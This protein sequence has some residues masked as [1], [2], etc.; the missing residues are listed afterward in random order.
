MNTFYKIVFKV[1]IVFTFLFLVI[2]LKNV[3]RIAA[4]ENLELIG[5]ENIS[6]SEA[7]D[8]VAQLYR[9]PFNDTF[10]LNIFGY[11]KIKDYNG[12]Y[13]PFWTN[14]KEKIIEIN[15]S[16]GIE[17]ISKH[18]FSG[19]KSVHDIKLPKTIKIIDDLAFSSSGITC[20]TIHANVEYIGNQAFYEC[21]ELVDVKFEENGKLTNI[22]RYAFS[23]CYSL[24]SIVLPNTVLQIGYGAFGS[25]M[26]LEEVVLPNS[27]NVISGGLFEDTN[28]K[29]I[30]IPDSVTEIE[31]FAFY[32]C[33]NLSSITFPKNLKT[34]GEQ[35]FGYCTSLSIVNFPE[36]VTSIERQAFI[37]CTSLTDVKMPKELEYLRL[38]A[39][40]ECT[41]LSNVFL[42]NKLD[43]I[44]S[45]VFLNCENLNCVY[46]DGTIESW[47]NIVFDSI[48]SN[49]MHYADNFFISNDA[50]EYDKLEEINLPNT[51]SEIGNYQFCGFKNV[52]N[53][54]FPSSIQ[55]ISDFAF[56]ECESLKIITIPNSVVSL[57]KNSFSDC[58]NLESISFEDETKVEIL[59]ENIFSNC[60]NLKKVDLA[61]GLKKIEDNAFS[62]V[63]YVEEINL[64]NSLVEIKSVPKCIQYNVYDNANY[65]GNKTNPYLYCVSAVNTDI[66]HCYI[67]EETKFIGEYAFRCCNNLLDLTIPNGIQRI[68]YYAFA[69]CDNIKYNLYK[70]VRYLGNEENPY[71]VVVGSEYDLKHYELAE[72]T[73]IIMKNEY[74]IFKNIIS[75]II[76]KNVIYIEEM[77]FANCSKLV[78]VYNLSNLDIIKGEYTHGFIASNA[79]V[80]HNCIDEPSIFETDS[81][82]G[83][84]F[85]NYQSECYLYSYIGNENDVVLPE[86]HNGVKY[87]IWKY[88]FSNSE[89]TSIVIPNTILKIDEWA[90]LNCNQLKKFVVPLGVE[91]EANIIASESVIYCQ[92]PSISCLHTMPNLLTLILHKNQVISKSFVNNYKKLSQFYMPEV[93]LINFDPTYFEE[94]IC[95]KLTL[96]GMEYPAHTSIKNKNT[97]IDYYFDRYIV[98]N[99]D[100][101]ETEIVEENQFYFITKNE[102]L[103]DNRKIYYL[104]AYLGTEKEIIIPSK[105]GD[106]NNPAIIIDS[107]SL[108]LSQMNYIKIS[109]KVIGICEEAIGSDSLSKVDITENLDF[110]HSNAIFKY[111]K[112]GSQVTTKYGGVTYVGKYAI[113]VDKTKTKIEFLEGTIGIAS[114]D[115]VGYE[116]SSKIEKVIFP[117]SLKFIGSNTWEIWGICSSLKEVVFSENSQL[118]SIGAFAFRGCYALKQIDLPNSI[119]EIGYG[120][121]NDCD[122]LTSFCIPEKVKI[123][124]E[125]ELQ[126]KIYINNELSL[127]KNSAYGV[128]RNCDKLENIDLSSTCLEKIPSLALAECPNLTT[129]KLNKNIKYIG[130][131]AFSDSDNINEVYYTGK[132]EDWCKIEFANAESNPIKQTNCFYVL[133]ETNEYIE[134]IEIEISDNIDQI[135]QYQFYGYE[136]LMKVKLPEMI[137]KIDDY[138]FFG[139]TGLKEFVIPF[140]VTDICENTFLDCYYLTDI[141]VDQYKNDIQFHPNWNYKANVYYKD[142]WY[143]V[144]L[145]DNNVEISSEIYLLNSPIN[146]DNFEINSSEGYCEFLYWEING[147]SKVLER[148]LIADQHYEIKAVYSHSYTTNITAPT[149]TKQGYTS[150]VCRCGDSYTDDYVDA[151]GHTEATDKAVEPTCTQTGLTEGKHCSVCN[152]VLVKQEVIEAL[153][154]DYEVVITAPTCTKQGYTTYTCHCGDSYYCFIFMT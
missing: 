136:K 27:L 130:A 31:I 73:K 93:E 100:F 65:L 9:N 72:T 16:E 59:P 128:W 17:N 95:D 142:E 52:T 119:E 33:R 5:E 154:H 99:E 129:I 102:Y 32:W 141:Y 50:S 134:V 125:I 139:C 147:N 131:A 153:G 7:D 70:N 107:Y 40:S 11:G 56:S 120:A 114:C 60:S 8:V 20:I 21:T 112:W 152:K 105:I 110:I 111:K 85:M 94:V 35:S 87:S 13:L 124:G 79:L 82:N 28:L 126:Q 104:K 149:C 122:S 106:D 15:I 2:N 117:A 58:N 54:F 45:Q 144:R 53:V 42:Y 80:V 137:R 63:N 92:V 26:E 96:L 23:A 55:K 47:C 81:D 6:S 4:N 25:C 97:G 115:E 143:I 46:Y 150:Y 75:I 61:E 51:I 135:G 76:P 14:Y 62:E 146:Y 18:C 84:L 34:I 123:I 37:G 103:D 86:Y 49:P 145:L 36:H 19:C 12:E 88:A 118:T 29:T 66:D 1:L 44:E 71:L 127:Y 41:S 57:G 24:K 69:D 109:D 89:I 116:N 91:C 74:Y 38:G 83:L 98:S 67:N 151:L 10:M 77:T 138:A 90:F 101:F 113:D 48:S 148:P 140:N 68:E 78:E 121:F 133:N 43:K 30:I 39:F 22:G 3:F 132:I 64:P 108:N